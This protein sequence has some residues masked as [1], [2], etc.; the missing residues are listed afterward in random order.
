M[1]FVTE[2]FKYWKKSFFLLA[3]IAAVPAIA[4]GLFF[5]PLTELTF[6]G[7]F[8]E[9]DIR[10]IKQVFE[11]IFEG[12]YR[13]IWPL[14]VAFV[15]LVLSVSLGLSVIEKHFRTGQLRVKAPLKEINNSVFPVLI[16]MLILTGIVI[17]WKLIL[18]GVV[19]LTHFIMQRGGPPGAA[20]IVVTA[21]FSVG[22][23]VLV[24]FL[25]I[26]IILWTPIMLVYGY[27]FLDACMASVKLVS[28]HTGNLLIGIM[29]PFTVVTIAEYLLFYL[30]LPSFVSIIV[31]CVLYLLLIVYFITFAMTA[32]FDLSKMERRDVKRAY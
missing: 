26:P 17:L 15:A 22:L 23:F 8:A 5:R 18:A 25:A 4:L 32:V 24:C 3:L 29:L 28:G 6:I 13:R 27:S 10:S 21:V 2:T 11:A 1:R 14:P 16:N 9:T 20:N 12:G 19:A 30:R 31:N 7:A